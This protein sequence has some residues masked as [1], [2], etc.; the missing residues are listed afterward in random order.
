MSEYDQT[1]PLLA[2]ARQP[3]DVVPDDEAELPRVPKALY[4]GTGGDIALR[5][6]GA[7]TDATFRNVPSGFLLP[8]RAQ[9]VR[10]TG[11]TAE[12]IVALA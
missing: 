7:D 5:G 1:D 10:A 3:F 2:S 11:T 9:F 4:I 6:V 12:D 8:V